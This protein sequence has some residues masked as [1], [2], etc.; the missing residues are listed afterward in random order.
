VRPQ[1]E[2]QEAFFPQDT[3]SSMANMGFNFNLVS[4]TKGAIKL[5]NATPVWNGHSHRIIF[6][7][8]SPTFLPEALESNVAPR[9]EGRKHPL[10]LENSS[11]Q[12]G[13][14]SVLILF[15]A[16]YQLRMRTLRSKGWLK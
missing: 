4:T 5:G 6:T 8:L 13:V 2:R 3:P 14:D 15:T 11:P 1:H 7:P 10:P 12:T 16:P 9:E